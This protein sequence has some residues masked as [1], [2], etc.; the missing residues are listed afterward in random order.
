V[1]V[2]HEIP[3]NFGTSI[4]G[5]T[6]LTLPAVFERSLTHDVELPGIRLQLHFSSTAWERPLVSAEDISQAGLTSVRVIDGP[7]EERATV[8]YKCKPGNTRM[9]YWCPGRNDAFFHVHVLE[10]ILDAGYDVYAIEHS[11]IGRS[12]QGVTAEEALL[13]SHNDNFSKLVEQFDAGLDF[14]YAQKAYKTLVWY[15]H[16]TGGL[17]STV[18]FREGKRRNAPAAVIFN[19]PFLDWSGGGIQEAFTDSADELAAISSWVG[20]NSKKDSA[21]PFLFGAGA[22][23]LSLASDYGVGIWMQYRFDPTLRNLFC[24]HVTWGWASEVS[25]QHEEL[26]AMEP[27]AIPTLLLTSQGDVVLDTE[28]LKERI[29]HFSNQATIRTVKECR[30]DMLLNRSVEKNDEVLGIMLQFLADTVGH[31]APRSK[32]GF[33][34]TF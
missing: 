28:D 1:E 24:T 12:N 27:V 9:L 5:K 3:S 31:V 11:R 19:S 25:R 7:V 15:A 33:L 8:T 6:R 4:A 29:G 14:A 26:D 21:A 2:R 22:G 13:T 18:Y 17:E 34:C 16:S 10:Q 32:G 20:G 23:D 30:H